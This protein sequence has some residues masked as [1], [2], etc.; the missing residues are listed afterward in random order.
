MVTQR[1]AHAAR[2]RLAAPR[3]QAQAEG[4]RLP[5]A[6]RLCPCSPGA[7]CAGP[8]GRPAA[9][10]LRPPASTARAGPA[11]S[12]AGRRA[13]ATAHPRAASSRTGTGTSAAAGLAQRGGAGAGSALAGPAPLPTQ[14]LT[15]SEA[16]QAVRHARRRRAAAKLI[17]FRNLVVCSRSETADKLCP[18]QRPS[19]GPSCPS[20]R[21][22]G[23]RGCSTKAAGPVPGPAASVAGRH[24]HSTVR[25]VTGR[26]TPD[27]YVSCS[28]PDVGAASAGARTPS[29]TL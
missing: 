4:E 20:R 16:L 1:L 11:R 7:G 28:S 27:T 12:G 14:T 3:L 2:T 23:A 18:H 10:P 13:G 9:R 29:P 15:P 8:P 6:R 26:Y 22:R 21:T 24:S 5:P 25:A 19:R 17:A